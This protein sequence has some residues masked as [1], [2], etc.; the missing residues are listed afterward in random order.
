M[1]GSDYT[2]SS[3]RVGKDGVS[4]IS[5]Q[6]ACDID[7]VDYDKTNRAI[8]SA[9]CT[10]SAHAP[11]AE[12]FKLR[13]RN[14]TDGGSFAD[15]TTS[16]GELRQG[17]SLGCITNTDPVGDTSGCAG[18][19]VDASEEVE[20]ESPLQ[21][22]SLSCGK[23]NFIETQWCVYFAIALDDKEYEF[24]LYSAIKGVS[25]GTLAATITTYIEVVGWSHKIQGVANANI[26]KVN[27]VAIAN[28][29][30]VNGV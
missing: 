28:I 11:G 22:V 16:E 5:W 12:S 25:C 23:D 9:I 3:S 14:K 26:A 17:T 29:A 7:V 13:W 27:G 1:A 20:D 24:E 2:V 6:A 30:K 15:L 10:S 4:S 8:I 19:T 21:T 18:G